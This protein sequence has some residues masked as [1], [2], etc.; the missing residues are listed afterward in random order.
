MRFGGGASVLLDLLASALDDER[1]ARILVLCSPRSTRKFQLPVSPKIAEIECGIATYSRL[2]RW[3]W[4]DYRLGAALKALDAHVFVSLCGAGRSG[5]HTPQI[6]MIQQSLPFSSEAMAFL[7]TKERIRVRLIG[8]AMKRACEVSRLVL[9]QTRTM[10][11][12]VKSAFQ[13]PDSR[14]EIVH[15]AAP[16]LDAP[17]EE[18]AALAS[19]RECPKGRRLL[20]V[21]NASRY[22]NLN[23]AINAMQV[24][25][26][27][28][29]ELTIF[30]TLNPGD[31]TPYPGTVVPIGYLSRS[32][33]TEA[34]RLADALIMPSVQETVGLPLLEAMTA[35]LPVIVADR[36]Y[37]REVCEEA[38]LFFDPADHQQL[39]CAIAMALDDPKLRE[40]L[41]SK[42][43]AI[44][45]RRR[46][47][48]AN[49]RI[50][51]LA[52]ALAKTPH[53]LSS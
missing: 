20:Y 12:A 2:Y 9:V 48:G 5:H 39:A 38:A 37:A 25:R 34:Y 46:E 32:A 31:P 29:P 22:K 17:R 47:I 4:L 49:R 7:S 42:G 23:V 8:Q 10:K 51:D 41:V 11:D 21:G 1:V 36:P 6:T 26:A 52:V 3:W 15:P 33:L 16:E 44:A 53:T 19:M 13:L 14:I 50:L 30:A 27:K 35:G 28:Y 43:L 40:D 45:R 18:S 24:L